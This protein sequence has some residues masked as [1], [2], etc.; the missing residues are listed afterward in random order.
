MGVRSQSDGESGSA[1]YGENKVVY[2][3]VNFAKREETV[4]LPAAMADVLAGGTKQTV[5]L[6]P[7]GVAVLASKQ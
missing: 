2:V 1:R 3:I 4:T 5:T 6:P 7:Y